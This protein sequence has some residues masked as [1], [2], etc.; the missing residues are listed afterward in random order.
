MAVTI[1]NIFV[2]FSIALD[3]WLDEDG[4]FLL[5]EDDSGYLYE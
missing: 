2:S 5:D 1:E 3:Y 4:N